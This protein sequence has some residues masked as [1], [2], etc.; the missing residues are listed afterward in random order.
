MGIID[1]LKGKK[2]KSHQEVI[3]HVIDN[4]RLLS[5]CEREIAEFYGLCA[6]AYESDRD[7]WKSMSRSE[8]HHSENIEKMIKLIRMNPENYTLGDSF[9]PASIRTFSLYIRNL[10]ERMRTEGIPADELLPLVDELEKS[11]FE[12]NYVKIIKTKNKEYNRLAAEIHSESKTHR[13]AVRNRL[14]KPS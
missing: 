1:K 12:L 7:F 5:E 10:I 9:N 14:S 3:N 2:R 6:E 4:L 13:D 8:T 11:A